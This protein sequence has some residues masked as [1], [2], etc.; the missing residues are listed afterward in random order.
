MQYNMPAYKINLEQN[1]L[2]PY[3]SLNEEMRKVIDYQLQNTKD[4]F[5]TNCTWEELREKYNAER[6]FWNEGGP[7]VFKTEEYIIDGPAGPLPLRFHSPSDANNLPVIIYLH[8]GGFTVGNNDTHSRIMRTL[9]A[10]SGCVVVGVDYKLAPEFK[11]PTQLYE[12][13]ATYEYLRENATLHNINANNIALAGDSGGAN[14]ALGVTTYLRDTSADESHIK[15]LLLY[16]GA[17][18]LSDSKTMR[19]YGTLLDGMRK[20]DLAYYQA[21]YIKAGE[22][23]NP[24]YA[25]LNNDLTY[26]IPP[27]YLCCGTL[28]PL[29]DDSV[30]L[31][32]IL[33][34]TN[35]QT[36]LDVLEGT[37][38]AFLQYTRF[39]PSAISCI[40][41]SAIFARPFLR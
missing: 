22:E 12:G 24:Y 4:A 23:D 7:S 27:T 36:Q 33:E 14:L 38:H 31:H 40:Q 9:C 39:M 37:L 35:V 6:V 11:F 17:Y 1:K 10:E 41:N 2:D 21:Q 25:S 32:S 20:E 8:G 30:L 18:G 3:P 16:Y 15:A 26:G 19:L 34:N 29:L 28:D 13:V 5:D